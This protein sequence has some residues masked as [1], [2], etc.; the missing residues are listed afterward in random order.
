MDVTNIKMA[1][2]WFG[3]SHGHKPY[4]FIAL[5]CLFR[6]RCRLNDGDDE[7]DDDDDDY[8][9]SCASDDFQFCSGPPSPGR[10]PGR[11]RTVMFLRFGPEGVSVTMTMQGSERSRP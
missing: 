1:I 9:P 2:T 5:R 8:D 3:D 4:E 10:P 6:P 7:D 11:V